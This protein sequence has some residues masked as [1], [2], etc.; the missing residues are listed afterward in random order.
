MADPAPIPPNARVLITGAGGFVGKH[1]CAA[2]EAAAPACTILAGHH[3]SD[4]IDRSHSGREAVRLDITDTAAVQIAIRQLRPTCVVHL[5]GISTVQQAR[6]DRRAAY[7]VN[8]YG[9]MNLAQAVLSEAPDAR[10]LF[11]GTSEV[12]GGS[13]K[14]SSGPLDETSVLDPT[15]AYAASKAAADLLIGQMAR[16]GLKAIRLRPF[17][18]TGPG[19]GE[20][21]VVPAFAA[22]IARIEAG[23]QDPIMQVGNLDAARDFLDVRDVVDA[24]VRLIALPDGA[25]EPGIALNL[26][27]GVPRRI[28][29]VLE[30]LRQLSRIPIAVRPDPDRMRPNDTP[31]AIGDADKARRLL[32]WAP[33]VP[34]ETTLADCLDDWRRTLA[35]R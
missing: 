33:K 20:Q 3:L 6:A 30:G 23:L 5:A 25:F 10:F 1:L 34:W 12:Y 4:R 29:D 22:Q 26:A 19:Q 27:S 17:N 11:I 28:S 14:T 7:D 2:L 13:F 35:E 16:D 8:L 18:H 31:F 32:G 15:N 9:T 21:F 24:Y